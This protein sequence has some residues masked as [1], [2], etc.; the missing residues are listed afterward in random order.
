[1]LRVRSVTVLLALAAVAAPASAQTAAPPELFSG[2]TPARTSEPVQSLSSQSA[3]ACLRDIAYEAAYSPDTTGAKADQAIILLLAAKSLSNSVGPVEPLLLKLLGRHP[4]G[5]YSAQ[6]VPWLQAYVDPSCDRVVVRDAIQSVLDRLKLWE[7]RKKLLEELAVRLA[8]KNAAV[9]SDL[10]MFLGF[11]MGEKADL[12]TAKMYLIRAYTC[13]EYNKVAFAKLAEIA[14]ND[15]GPG[16]YLEHLRL[17]LRENPLNLDAA[18]NFSQYAQQLQ[19]YDLSALSYQYCAELY[20]YLYPTQLLP[21]QIYLPWAISSYNTKRGQPVTMQIAESVRSAGGFDLLLEALASRAAAKAGS[22]QEARRICR[23]AEEKAQQLFQS[24]SQQSVTAAHLAWFYCFADPNARQALDWA[25]KAYSM[26]ANSPPTRALLAY[27]LS[28]NGQVDWAKPM[29]GSCAD[30]QIADLVQARIQ[31]AAGSKQEAVQTLIA[32]INKDPSSLAAERAKEMLAE[33]QSQYVPPIN[34]DALMGFLARRLGQAVAPQFL[35][36]D[37]M[38]QVQFS[39]RGKEFA[40]GS[41]IEGVVTIVNQGPEP[42]VITEDSL[43]NGGIR[44][45]ARVSGSLQKQIAPLVSQTVRTALEVQPGKSYAISVRLSTGKLRE[46]LETY[47]QASL[48]IE[49]V[50]YVDPVVAADGSVSSR[51]VDL[52]PVTAAA[53]RPGVELT[54]GY[55]RN[56]FNAISSGQQGQRIATAQLFTSLLKEQ[57]AMAGHGTLYP[58]RNAQW[59]P[60]LLRSALTSESGLLL[61]TGDDGWVV[62]VHT[63][64]DMLSLSLDEGLV[65]TVA[66][67]LNRPQWPVRMMALYLLANGSHGDFQPVLDWFAQN[68]PNDLVRSLAMT[69]RPTSLAA[70]P[71]GPTP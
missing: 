71:P 40:F 38:I 20:R 14:P 60:A 18:M 2:Q 1:M 48:E 67:D 5:D 34:T 25:N 58:Y 43:F 39:V 61:S 15:I 10:A 3:A 16:V 66:K 59:M 57:Q 70:A 35:P 23:Q 49:F 11:L 29:L 32:A 54:A 46:V 36:P 7:G 19:L 44:I 37:K 22:P 64:A 12:E 69:S 27:A 13:N 30:N 52:K 50:L 62:A 4:L 33:L 9:D 53:K 8:N 47:P 17:V 56:R 65:A 45:D 26:D 28:L 21:P 31:A 42:L 41:D 68:D 51:L 63:M 6:I 55:V 24:G